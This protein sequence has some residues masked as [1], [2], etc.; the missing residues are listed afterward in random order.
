MLFV[1]RYKKF[2]I[3]GVLKLDDDR[4]EL[5]DYTGLSVK[6]IGR[7][8]KKLEADGVITRENN[9]ILIDENQYGKMKL[10]LSHVLAED[11]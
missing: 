9:R 3:N 11:E 4:Q 7:A 1:H 10:V 8:L 6:T 5:A 2:A